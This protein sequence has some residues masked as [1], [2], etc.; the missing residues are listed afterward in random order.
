MKERP[1]IFSGEMVRAI[2]EGRKTQTRRVVKYNYDVVGDDCGFPDYG[3]VDSRHREIVDI[4]SRCPYGNPGDSLWVRETWSDYWMNED[5][6]DPRLRT[7]HY[8]STW[9]KSLADDPLWKPSIFMPRWASRILL[10]V[11]SVRVERLHDI[12]DNSSIAE[13]VA[14]DNA[15]PE[16]V[17]SGWC[18]GAYDTPRDAFS[19]LWDSINAKRGYGWETN[20][21]VWVVLFKVIDK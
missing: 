17:S 21:W 20:P 9:D 13:G 5:V 18:P 11:V 8:R 16:E 10:E 7:I 2:L 3:F 14:W 1:I 19:A 6:L 12:T 4:L 15:C